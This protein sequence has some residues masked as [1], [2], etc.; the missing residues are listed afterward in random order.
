MDS[1]YPSLTSVSLK[2]FISRYNEHFNSIR[3]EHDIFIEDRGSRIS[4]IHQITNRNTFFYRHLPENEPKKLGPWSEEETEIFINEL[5]QGAA[6]KSCD[7][8]TPERTVKWGLFSL[9]IPG[10]VGY[11]CFIRYLQLVKIGRIPEVHEMPRYQNVHFAKNYQPALL[12]YQIRNLVNSIDTLI[13]NHQQVTSNQ[14]ALMAI[15]L[16]YEPIHL[17]KKA[18]I[19][20]L[21]CH[22]YNVMDSQGNYVEEVETLKEQYID[23]AKYEPH[24]LMN[25]FNI[26][27]FG[28]SRTWIFN[29][30][31]NN[32]YSYRKA[33]YVRR[34]AIQQDAVDHYL[35]HLSEAVRHYGRDKVLNMDETHVLLNNFAA[36]TIAKKGQN[37]VVIDK[38]CINEK[39]GTTYI[40]TIAMDPS[41]KFPLYCIAKGKTPT[42]EKKY[43]NTDPNKSEMDHSDSGWCSVDVMKRYLNWISSQMGGQPF[44]L[45][46][47][48]Y[49][50]HIA[51]SIKEEASNLNIECIYVPANGT[52]TYQP[53]DRKIF[54][55]VKKQ[56]AKA[57]LHSSKTDTAQT[58]ELYGI[59][60]EE[61]IKIWNNISTS[62]LNSAWDIPDLKLDS[63]NLSNEME[64][65]ELSN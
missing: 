53:L 22:G 64:E 24:E 50:T 19:A 33:H 30:M 27:S 55:I 63:V 58:K 52:G 25:E 38:S 40:G 3:F 42:C 51:D 37:D 57:E 4:K 17:A 18:A 12:P 11:Q 23:Q 59:V 54:G 46:M 1:L 36:Y 26:D 16:F 65:E 10:R 62:A 44:A 9:G 32:N 8:I 15:E 7:F 28:A 5:Y 47:D 14:I 60:H 41:I 45:V 31:E 56:L 29:F 13:E 21:L 35:K 2:E 34:G 39:A 6:N 49:T 61:V 48:I 43:N 20:Y